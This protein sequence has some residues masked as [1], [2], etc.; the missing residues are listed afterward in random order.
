MPEFLN[1]VT[2]PGDPSSDNHA[3]RRA[4]IEGQNGWGMA[5]YGSDIL[6]WTG[7]PSYSTT[8]SLSFGR[9]QFN[10]FWLRK[11]ATLSTVSFVFTTAGSSLTSGQN[12]VALFD[13]SGTQVAISADQTTAFGSVGLKTVS[14]TTPY[15]AQ[16]GG[17]YV[18][19]LPNGSGTVPIM[20]CLGAIGS[21]SLNFGLTTANAR[22]LQSGSGNTSMPSSVTLSSQT[23]SAM[24]YLAIIK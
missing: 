6:A 23:L 9:I 11:A 17:Y 10:K 16:P 2:L 4:W 12:F 14:M 22:A 7:S 8:A 5:D 3:A 21:S 19:I 24:N 20:V 1:Q 13:S 18:A 15:S